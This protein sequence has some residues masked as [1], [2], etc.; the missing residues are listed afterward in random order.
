MCRDKNEPQAFICSTSLLDEAPTVGEKENIEH[1]NYG[2]ERERI[3]QDCVTF[4][5]HTSF[6]PSIQ[7]SLVTHTHKAGAATYRLFLKEKQKRTS[8]PNGKLQK[9]A[10]QI[11]DHP[12]TQRKKRKQRT[13]KHNEEK[14]WEIA[15]KLQISIPPGRLA[16]GHHGGVRL[17]VA[18]RR[19]EQHRAVHA[20]PVVWHENEAWLGGGHEMRATPGMGWGGLL[21][22]STEALCR[23]PGGQRPPTPGSV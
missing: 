2:H 23:R 20:G 1:I 3:D 18:P 9:H 10:G 6:L 22:T 16:A 4:G 11:M 13:K 5:A 15:E 7:R 8:D 21:N 19:L 17:L 14:L 12:K